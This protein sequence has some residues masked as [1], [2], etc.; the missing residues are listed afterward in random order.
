MNLHEARWTAV[1]VAASALA[2]CG[3]NVA[4]SPGTGGSGGGSATASGGGSGASTATSASSSSS[5]SGSMMCP[6]GC[7]KGSA[8]VFDTGECALQ[9]DGTGFTPCG[10]GLVCNGCGTSSCFGCK[11]CVAVCLPA[12]PGKCDDHDDCAKGYVCIYGMGTCAPKCNENPPSCPTPDLICNPCA[13]ATCPVC[14][15]C[16]GACTESF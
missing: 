10:P 13:T 3:G 7:P 4:I 14:D 8:C 15:S 16:L 2:G 12:Q 9:C 5:S 1:L 6:G 11:D